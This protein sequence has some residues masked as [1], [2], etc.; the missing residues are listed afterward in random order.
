MA[1]RC[2]WTSSAICSAKTNVSHIALQDLEDNRF[3]VAELYGKLANIFADLPSRR[4]YSSSMLKTLVSGDP[5]TAER[6][7][8]RPFVFRN[9][10]KLIFSANA[11]PGTSDRSHAFYRRWMI[12][13]FEHTFN[14]EGGNPAPKPRTTGKAPMRI[15][16]DFQPCGRGVT[17]ALQSRG[18]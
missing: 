15:A 17:A 10:A 18:F 3:R 11:I 2:C 14:G 9:V 8:E 13:P 12:V 1:N 16:R 5:I 4:L 7:H 6:K